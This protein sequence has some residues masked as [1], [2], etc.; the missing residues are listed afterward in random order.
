LTDEK[1]TGEIQLKE[2][3]KNQG[4]ISRA[5]V[6]QTIIEVLEDGVKKNQ[7]FEIITGDTAVKKAV[8]AS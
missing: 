2:K 8:I 5:D 1:S 6:A 7:A 4:S 3:L